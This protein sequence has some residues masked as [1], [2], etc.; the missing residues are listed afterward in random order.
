MGGGGAEEKGGGVG[1][2][3]GV[4]RQRKWGARLKRKGG[5]AEKRGVG[6]RR[7]RKWKELEGEPNVGRAGP[8]EEAKQPAGRERGSAKGLTRVQTLAINHSQAGF[9][10]EAGPAVLEEPDRE[11]S[12]GEQQDEDE[13]VGAVLPVALLGLLLGHDLLV[14]GSRLSAAAVR[15]PCPVKDAHCEEQPKGPH[16]PAGSGTAADATAEGCP[17]PAA[18]SHVSPRLPP[19]P[20]RRPPAV[21]P[22]PEGSRERGGARG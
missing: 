18:P 16:E 21:G 13:Q 19:L 15:S 6:G 11:N 14:H 9:V 22:L 12:E 1:S 20:H 5:E 8:G 3:K 2:E 17:P 4:E 10:Q 7:G